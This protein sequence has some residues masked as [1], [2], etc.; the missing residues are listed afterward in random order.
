MTG[1]PG[2]REERKGRGLPHTEGSAFSQRLAG[3][4]TDWRPQGLRAISKGRRGG[5]WGP[6]WSVR[7]RTWEQSGGFSKLVVSVVGFSFRPPCLLWLRVG[8]VNW[9][10]LFWQV[11]GFC[12]WRE[13][14]NSRLVLFHDLFILLKKSWSSVSSVQQSGWVIHVFFSFSDDCPL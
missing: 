7:T 4:Q 1:N 12:T 9:G 10:S 2:P 14:S 6:K 8:V 13:K 11:A 3:P 5:G